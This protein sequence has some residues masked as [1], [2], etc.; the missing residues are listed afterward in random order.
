[1]KTILII[2]SIMVMVFGIYFGIKGDWQLC[3]DPQVCDAI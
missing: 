3:D 2:F 1:M